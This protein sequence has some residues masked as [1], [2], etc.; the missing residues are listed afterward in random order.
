MC[1]NEVFCIRSD[2][3]TNA[4]KIVHDLFLRACRKRRIMKSVV[5]CLHVLRKDRTRFFRVITDRQNDFD[6]LAEIFVD[7]VGCMMRNVDA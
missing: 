3:I 2:L 5:N 1:L 7:M 6:F 4:A